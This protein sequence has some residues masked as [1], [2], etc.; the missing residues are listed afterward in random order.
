MNLGG[1]SLITGMGDEF[2][3]QNHPLAILNISVQIKVICF[4]HSDLNTYVTHAVQ[5][6]IHCLT[7]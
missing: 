6:C 5:I 4:A 1:W 7:C 2:E 3:E